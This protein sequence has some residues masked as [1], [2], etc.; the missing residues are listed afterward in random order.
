[1]AATFSSGNNTYVLVTQVVIAYTRLFDNAEEV[2]R[3]RI[4]ELAEFHYKHGLISD[5]EV[6]DV[7]IIINEGSL[8][9]PIKIVIKYKGYMEIPQGKSKD[10]LDPDMVI[11]TDVQQ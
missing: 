3:R 1:M 2:I 10:L 6:L 8:T 5:F 11:P 9:M 4:Q 7:D